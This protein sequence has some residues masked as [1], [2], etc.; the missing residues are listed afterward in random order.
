MAETL[1]SEMAWSIDADAF[2]AG[3][4]ARQQLAFLV[5]YAVLAPSSRC[6]PIRDAVTGR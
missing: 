3:G 5:R 1:P 2:T 4:S 6:R